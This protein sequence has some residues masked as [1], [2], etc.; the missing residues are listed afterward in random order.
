MEKSD[1]SYEKVIS[2][3]QFN[4]QNM[5][6]LSIITISVFVY[7]LSS[8]LLYP[9][10][11]SAVIVLSIIP[12]FIISSFYGSIIGLIAGILFFLI[13]TLIINLLDNHSINLNKLF[14]EYGV[15]GTLSLILM[16][17]VSGRLSEL[18]RELYE[19]LNRTKKL[20][21]ELE[22]KNK[23]IN[24]VKIKLEEIQEQLIQSNKI[25]TVGQLTSS[26]IHQLNN[27]ITGVLGLSQLILKQIDAS[28][29]FYQDLKII[30]SLALKC[31]EIISSFLQYVH[32]SKF[33]L[34]PLN[35]NDVLE[36]A[37]KLIY[38]YAY[39]NKIEIIK[40]FEK[41]I[42]LFL[43][44]S[45][46]LEQAFVN[47]ILNSCES[48]Q[49]EGIINI[50]TRYI[51]DKIEILFIDTGP[52]I[53]KE[54][55]DKVFTPFFTTKPAGKGTGLGLAL[56]KDIIEKHGGTIEVKSPPPTNNSGTAFIVTIP[57]RK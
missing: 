31:R 42:P 7:F 50:S 36:S 15:G 3:I 49:N 39:L 24:E 52:G 23:E 55:I 8:Y 21:Q 10:M 27:P 28:N 54:I 48:M 45:R 32:T 35:I 29:N 19:Q 34:N 40:N 14:L 1:I 5:V 44:D 46:K 11:N 26:I 9:Y 25:V 56:S 37:L 16:G 51:N 20:E 33:E 18:S 12:L 6:K 13:N 47:I 4:T 17:P 53:K 30:E 38:H 41:N 22:Q 2:L 57:V 43:G